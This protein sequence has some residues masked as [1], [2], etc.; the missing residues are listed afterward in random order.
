MVGK[1]KIPKNKA[2]IFA[3]NHQNAFMDAM[4]VVLQT[5]LQQMIFLARADIFQKDRV[6]KFL[7]LCKI[8]PIFRLRDGMS[9]LSNNDAIFDTTIN[10]LLKGRKVVIFPEGNHDGHR[11]LRPLKKG[12]VRM[13][14]QALDEKN[15]QFELYIVP[16]GIDYS[17]YEYWNEEVL[18]Q[19]GDPI[20]L[21]DSYSEYKNNPQQAYHHTSDKLS[22]AMKK[23]MIHIPDM[24]HYD[25]YD[26]LRTFLQYRFCEIFN[27]DEAQYINRFHSQQKMIEKIHLIQKES[28]LLFEKLI[29]LTREHK[30]IA[31]ENKIEHTVFKKSDFIRDH[32]LI[33]III[34][35]IF[36]PII[37]TGAFTGALIYWIV[38]KKISTLKDRQFIS[39][40]QFLLAGFVGALN[41]LIIA[42]LAGVLTSN[43]WLFL[44][45]LSLM[46]FTALAALYFRKG[47]SIISNKKRWE[48]FKKNNS[49]YN[50]YKKTENE[51][52]EILETF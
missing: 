48:R 47:L 26:H 38:K 24:N 49:K 3:P 35:L 6:A 41:Y 14:Y 44:G 16:V 32:S 10:V 28:P 25:E 37:L 11:T 1:E 29:H 22:A 17:H 21:N 20:L 31:I 9:S 33:F 46:P 5:P 19:F 2:I 15:G 43:F 8:M 39:S 40:F 7:K 27:L 52:V 4:G 23:L 12:L 13:A 45:A 36:S 30:S 18:V 34:A 51:L 42:I 50:D